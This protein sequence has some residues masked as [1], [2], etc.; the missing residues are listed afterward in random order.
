MKCD[1][2]KCEKT[3]VKYYNHNYNIK[4]KNISFIAKRRFCQKCNTL[5]YDA[6]LDDEAS[7]TAIEIFNK[8]YGITKDEIISLRNKYNLSQ[9][10]FSKIIGC[11]KKT[12]ISYEKGTSIPN[13]SYFI[14]LKSLMVKPE[15][16]ITFIDA[17]KEHFTSKE[18]DKINSKI[19]MN[20][21][22][23]TT[24]P[25]E[26]NGYSKTVK[27]KISNVI[28]FF[29]KS[30]ILKTKLLKEMFY[31]DFLY[32]KNFGKSITGLEYA[33]LPFGPVPDQYEQ[34]LCNEVADNIID[35]VVSYNGDYE[36]HN[37]SSKKEFNSNLFNQ[38]ELMILEIIKNKFKDFSSRDIE[39]YSHKEEAYIKTNLYDKISY[40]YAFDINIE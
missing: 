10:L 32:Y 19:D 34:I 26:Y 27:E 11:A 23:D 29:A 20:I 38:D 37:I 17:N 16:I 12:L 24:S 39:D 22:S 8:N 4:G 35:Y 6:I 33:K 21:L 14:L 31:A 1:N 18:I 25:N 28:L 7:K 3:Y 36:C 9:E 40:E 13:D 30:S 5:V 2:C 15:T